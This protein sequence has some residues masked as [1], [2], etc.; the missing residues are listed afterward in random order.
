M[1]QLDVNAMQLFWLISFKT[2][3]N[4]KLIATYIKLRIIRL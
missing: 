4:L 2:K 3:Q 1:S